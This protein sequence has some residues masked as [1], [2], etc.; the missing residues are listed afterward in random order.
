MSPVLL[1][2]P[3]SCVPPITAAAGIAA[4]AKL[5]TAAASQIT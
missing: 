3:V 4:S 2:M 5:P 1:N